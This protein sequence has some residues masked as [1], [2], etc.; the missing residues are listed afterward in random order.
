M[1]PVRARSPLTAGRIGACLAVLAVLQA[2][3]PPGFAS[4][5]DARHCLD[6]GDDRAIARCAEQYRPGG[7]RK[8][9]RASP[10]AP[11]PASPPA[12]APAPAPAASVAPAVSTA[13]AASA[14]ASAAP[15][16]PAPVPK[17]KRR[18]REVD[19]RH[20]LDLGTIAAIT[21]CAQK[22]R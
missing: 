18:A 4:A 1:K 19:A 21:R 2:A 16:P 14:A 6:A 5:V 22:Y 15:A 10:A 3:S 9:A 7:P 13:P 11:P 20:C 17:R 8:V 12:P